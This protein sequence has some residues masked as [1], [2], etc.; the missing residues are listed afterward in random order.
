MKILVCGGRDYL[1]YGKVKEVLDS[2]TQDTLNVCIIQGGAKGADYLAKKWAEENG[3]AC[4]E[5][6]ANWNVHEKAAGPIRNKWM[7]DFGNPDLV[8]SFPG[9]AGTK[10]METWTNKYEIPLK[11]IL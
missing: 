11:R 2:I 7:L 1:N 6:K 3:V 4:M 9:G 10:N 5:F 8:V